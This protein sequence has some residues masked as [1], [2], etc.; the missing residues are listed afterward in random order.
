MLEFSFI[1][2]GLRD[3][4]RDNNGEVLIVEFDSWE[5]ADE[6]IMSSNLDQYGWTNQ[7]TQKY[8][9]NDNK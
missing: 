8:C 6:Y 2:R 5:A 3:F 9:W 7:G 1:D 4:I